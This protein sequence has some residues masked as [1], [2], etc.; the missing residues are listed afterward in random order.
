MK[1]AKYKL[2]LLTNV[3]YKLTI[4]IL[5]SSGLPNDIFY[6]IVS[7]SDIIITK[8]SKEP[9]LKILKLPNIKS[10]NAL[11]VGDREEVD[12]IPAKEVGMTTGLLGQNPKF[13]DYSITNIRHII[14]ILEQTQKNK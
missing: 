14:K 7:R 11:M 9:F 6:G 13:A 10:Q 12:I 2:G 1:K 5:T 8:P 4:K 3:P